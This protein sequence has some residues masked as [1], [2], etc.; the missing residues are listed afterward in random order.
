MKRLLQ[1]HLENE[2]TRDGTCQ[3]INSQRGRYHGYGSQ[4]VAWVQATMLVI[5]KVWWQS[6]GPE[7]DLISIRRCACTL[8]E[9][10]CKNEVIGRG[11]GASG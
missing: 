3:K 9:E 2:I 6:L 11:E 7:Y 8:A 10:P 1:R 5:L 4:K